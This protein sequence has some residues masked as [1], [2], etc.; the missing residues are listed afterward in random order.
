MIKKALFIK[1]QGKNLKL[2]A[3]CIIILSPFF[4]PNSLK[5][6]TIFMSLSLIFWFICGFKFFFW[7][8]YFLIIYLPFQTLVILFTVPIHRHI[9]LLLFR[10][11]ACYFSYLETFFPSLSSAKKFVHSGFFS[12]CLSSSFQHVQ[13][14]IIACEFVPIPKKNIQPQENEVNELFGGTRCVCCCVRP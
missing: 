5:V 6:W 3:S 1:N 13:Y 7:N 12:F 14:F 11:P 2:Y 9:L 8:I 4:S 10:N